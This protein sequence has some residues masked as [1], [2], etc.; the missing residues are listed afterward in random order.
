MNPG[1]T[2]D[3]AARPGAVPA[4]GS[5]FRDGAGID[6]RMRSVDPARGTVTAE[7]VTALPR[8]D[9]RRRSGATTVLREFPLLRRP[10][11]FC[12]RDCIGALPEDGQVRPMVRFLLERHPNSVPDA[13]AMLG[14]VFP[15][16]RR[17]ARE[18]AAELYRKARL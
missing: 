7:R 12:A 13:L 6:W 3:G 10:A 9:R 4:V 8:G 15:D 11:S 1:E 14:R 18:E 5:R 17:A 16:V 2:G